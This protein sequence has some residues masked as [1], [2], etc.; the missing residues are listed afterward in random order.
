MGNYIS[1]VTMILR[2]DED[3]MK[4]VHEFSLTQDERIEKRISVDQLIVGEMNET[5]IKF[6]DLKKAIEV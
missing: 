4:D 5:R 3:E 1:T 6:V 2:E